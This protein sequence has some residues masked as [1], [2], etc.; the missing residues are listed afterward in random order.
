M[1]IQYTK[2]LD[3]G[4]FE[5][6]TTL[7]CQKKKNGNYSYKAKDCPKTFWGRT[8]AQVSSVFL[9]SANFPGNFL[10]TN[11]LENSKTWFEVF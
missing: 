7:S 5:L 6:G 2:N 8:C 4:R 1:Q 9:M 10:R 3:P 11:V